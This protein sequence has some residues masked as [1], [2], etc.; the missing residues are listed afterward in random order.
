MIKKGKSNLQ[1]EGKRKISNVLNKMFN[2][3]SR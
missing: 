1:Q 2:E 3:E